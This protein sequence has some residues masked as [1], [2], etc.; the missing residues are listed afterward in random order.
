MAGGSQVQI[1]S[2]NRDQATFYSA[3]GQ[4]GAINTD[5]SQ[6][7]TY[8]W[9]LSTGESY[10]G[11][12]VSIELSPDLTDPL[13]ITMTATA[14]DGTVCEPDTRIVYPADFF[15]FGDS[16]TVTKI[17]ASTVVARPGQIIEFEAEVIDPVPSDDYEFFW[18]WLE[19]G[20]PKRF[21]GD[22]L[23]TSFPEP[24]DPEALYTLSVVV[25]D[26][27]G[28]YGFSNFQTDFINVRISNQANLPPSAEIYDPA[29]PGITLFQGD[30]YTFRGRGNDPEG[31]AIVDYEWRLLDPLTGAFI[32]LEGGEETTVTFENLGNAQVWLQVTDS[33]GLVSENEERVIVEVL[34]EAGVESLKPTIAVPSGNTRF[35]ENDP[36]VLIGNRSGSSGGIIPSVWEFRNVSTGELVQTVE[37]LF[38]GRTSL[39]QQGVY[40]IFLKGQIGSQTTSKSVLN[41]RIIAVQK[42]D[43]NIPPLLLPT[44]PNS[45]YVRNG[46][47]IQL[48][49]EVQDP[50]G[51]SGNTEILWLVDG[52]LSDQRG[53]IASFEFNKE[54][55]AFTKGVADAVS[56]RV[57]AIDEQGKPN[58]L[59][60]GYSVFVYQDRLIPEPL[61][62]GLPSL[63]TVYLPLGTSYPLSASLAEEFSEEI[64]YTW[65]VTP[66]NILDS[67]NL[68][69]AQPGN[70]T[71]T[72]P[73][74][75]TIQ[76][77]VETADGSLRYLP[78]LNLYLYVF[79][80]TAPPDGNIT[81]PSAER[82]VVETGSSITLE[83]QFGDPNLLPIS[84]RT[85]AFK[86]VSH[87]F[88]W[89][90]FAP[91]GGFQAVTQEEPL[92]LS[93]DQAGTWEVVFTISNSLGLIDLT[94]D[95]LTIEVTQP[96][97]DSEFE[98]N[99]TREEAVEVD[100]GNFGGLSVSAEDPIDWYRFCLEEAGSL[101]NFEFDLS[102]ATGNVELQLFLDENLVETAEL[103]AGGL[104]SFSFTGAEAGIYYMR[105]APTENAASKRTGL[106]F[107]IDIEVATP[108]LIFPYPKSDEVEDT[109]LLLINP[110]NGEADVTLVARG[111]DG[112]ELGKF[113]LKLGADSQWSSL[114]SE[115]FNSFNLLK[116]GWV[117]V[118]AS[119]SI[120]G[121]S[122]TISRDNATALA[123]PAI[124][125]TLDSLVVPHIAQATAQWFTRASVINNSGEQVTT[126]LTA[127]A[128]DFEVSQVSN[129]FESSIIDFEAFFGGTLPTGSDWA[130]FVESDAKSNL[131]GMELFGT[132]L[133]SPRVAGLNLAN[134]SLKDP[135][136][137]YVRRNLYFPHVAGSD[138]WTG[139]AFVNVAD[140]A[141]NVRLVG[142]DNQGQVL[143]TA[144][145]NLA[146]FAKEVR[147]AYQFFDGMAVDDGLAWIALETDGFVQGYE[148]FGDND[149]D[150]TILSGFPAVAGGS[151]ELLFRKV[152]AGDDGWTGIAVVNL[153]EEAAANLVYEAIAE[154]GSVLAS[155][156]RTI[157][158]L[159]KDVALVQSLFEGGLP[160][161]TAWL[162]MSSD[163]PVAGFQLYGDN[164]GQHM[165]G[166][167]AQ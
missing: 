125:S 154:D 45:Q 134:A 79:D 4:L 60:A 42:R 130:R 157:L 98:P 82:V 161:G 47:S 75:Y 16:P 133:G 159:R 132:K 19:D 135:G 25:R 34:D 163:Q 131:A 53:T 103:L 110:T 36:I 127:E 104:A 141:T 126:A 12:F 56:V 91:D 85:Q 102:E 115:V 96:R 6:E 117:Q 59:V 89:E 3:V 1:I 17:N 14:A 9:E 38:P 32:P 72:E 46:E 28:F 84:S 71:P 37:G 160:E 64:A 112:S 68:E 67:I 136:F 63:E 58:T 7:Y 61:I 155:S 49:M 124:S 51:N 74:F 152:Q 121:L 92:T 11:Q 52:E 57:F 27:D 122:T 97:Q 73:G 165:A 139:I 55:S 128:G 54:E 129:V 48:G 30:S 21:T 107:S 150:A 164:G 94:P 44:G 105:F 151:T 23:R 95:R 146:P 2:P 18:Y 26:S 114:V 33:E 111:F 62:N 113:G 5:F 93:F 86:P 70:Y 22:V 119:R 100:F 81:K 20:R 147:L 142:Y 140:I 24:E 87:S 166:V 90:I 41:T 83:G 137:T 10:T 13:V 50:D 144:D 156:L 77:N 65:S 148:L 31:D 39:A 99:N 162:R 143:A 29:G 80:T 88:N 43:E 35:F 76:L 109:E 149:S 8:A 66:P 158:A 123:E 69:G 167:L 138:F 145:M 116:L 118:L 120:T 101:V 15:A 40:E 108:R 78:S 106:D 153:A